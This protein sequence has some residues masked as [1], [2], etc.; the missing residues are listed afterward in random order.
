M[1]T[2]NSNFARMEIRCPQ[3]SPEGTGSLFLCLFGLPF[4]PVPV[5]P[6]SCKVFTQSFPISATIPGGKLWSFIPQL[7]VP[8]RAAICP[9]AG[10]HEALPEGAK[11]RNPPSG[12]KLLKDGRKVPFLSTF[13]IADHCNCHHCCTPSALP[14]LHHAE[15]IPQARHDALTGALLCTP[16]APR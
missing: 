4:R 7:F 12:E 10:D 9:S 15:D 13:C 8:L 1:I 2:E 6:T 3:S 5:L 16:W 11:R 14:V